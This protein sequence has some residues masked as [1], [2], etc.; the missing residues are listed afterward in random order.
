MKKSHV[1]SLLE[2]VGSLFVVAGS[3]PHQKRLKKKILAFGSRPHFDLQDA[4]ANV[5]CEALLEC[6]LSMTDGIVS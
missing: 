4:T 1:C 2:T 5:N 3:G 6:I